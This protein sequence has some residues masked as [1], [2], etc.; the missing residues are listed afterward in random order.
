[1]R[2]P[3]SPLSTR[4]CRTDVNVSSLKGMKRHNRTNGAQDRRSEYWD[5]PHTDVRA[6]LKSQLAHGMSTADTLAGYTA[7]LG[8]APMRCKKPANAV[9]HNG[10]P[11]SPALDEHLSH[12]PDFL[13]RGVTTHDRCQVYWLRNR[14]I[15]TCRTMAQATFPKTAISS[16]P[17]AWSARCTTPGFALRQACAR[18]GIATG[19]RVAATDAGHQLNTFH[20]KNAHQRNSRRGVACRHR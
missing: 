6:I 7:T 8:N 18:A 9:P 12:A 19:Y 1:M 20:E 16:M 4:R 15:Q 14:T 2:W 10:S 17:H 13:H 3:D 5:L 11:A